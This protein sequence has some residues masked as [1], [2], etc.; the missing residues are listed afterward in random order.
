MIKNTFYTLI[1]LLFSTAAALYLFRPELLADYID[2]E[3]Q[4]TEHEADD[5][6]AGHGGHGG[7]DD[8]EDEAPKGPHRG[9]LLQQ[10]DFSLEVTVFET[11]VE[12][13]FHVYAYEHGQP[14]APG[15]VS[16]QI[17]LE[18]L[19]GQ[20]DSFN[21]EPREDYLQGDGVVVEPHSFDVSVKAEFA[22]QHYEWHYDNYEGRVQIEP[23]IAEQTGLKTEPAG[24]QIIHES[25]ELTGRVQADPN[26]LSH[27]RARFP[28]MVKTVR[29][30][31]GEPVRKGEVLVIIQS[32]ESLQN[33]EVRA[34]IS[35]LII[36]RDVQVG[37]ATADESLFTIY[38]LSQVWVELDVFERDLNRVQAGQPVYLETL[39]GDSL[40]A[41][42]SWLSPMAAHASQSIQARVV[43]DNPNNRL[44]P[45]QFIR[46]RVTIAEHAVPLAVRPSGIQS[47]RD[48]QV[49]FAQF[50]DRYE[51][52][53]LEL[54]RRD[55]N[56][57]EVL[58]G[59]KP[60][61][62][63]VT[64]NSYLI[65]ADIEKSGATHDH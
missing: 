14:V 47:F 43:V 5:E 13:E 46:A 10:G 38:D 15:E 61:T 42:I 51:V 25:I 16:V 31:L 11:G 52:R 7:H 9:R 45:G 23:R 60:G 26:R 57:V 3:A 6:H 48:F 33:Y 20:R 8:H 53:M 2:V 40:E 41:T 27:V 4:H 22:G 37:E 56:W 19:D 21:F 63:Y 39:G 18:R 35:G 32:D 58:G 29:K 30:Q 62:P 49:V 36:K 50:D 1:V 64:E 12:P 34:P 28:G 55:Q 54:G 44:R 17:E 24:A 59:L 65:K